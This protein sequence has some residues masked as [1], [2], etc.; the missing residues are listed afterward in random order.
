MQ[1]AHW[2]L[3]VTW[4]PWLPVPAQTRLPTRAPSDLRALT[5]LNLLYSS[6]T[7][8][9]EPGLHRVLVCRA[10]VPLNGP[11]SEQKLLQGPFVHAI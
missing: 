3:L 6:G 4:P 9:S 5:N 10:W 2:V 1:H 7:Y 8:S 11:T